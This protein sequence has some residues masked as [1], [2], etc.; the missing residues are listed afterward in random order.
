M[1]DEKQRDKIV[2][3]E[4]Q[5]I[6]QKFDELDDEVIVA[7]IENRI[8]EEWVYHFKQDNQDV[9]G[10]GKAGIDGCVSELGKKGIA[11]RE[12]NV[13]YALDPTNPQY[14][15]F[16]ATVSKHF[17]GKD[18]AEAAVER[19]I[20]TKRQWTKLKKSD[21]TVIDNRFWFEQGS[22]KALRNAKS[23]LIPEDIKA[24]IISFAK[25]HKKVKEL[26]PGDRGYREPLNDN[27]QKAWPKISLKLWDG[28]TKQ[29]TKFEALGQFGEAK[30]A[31]G[32]ENY[33]EILGSLGFEHANQIPP[34]K[35]PE[36]FKVLVT[37][38][39]QNRE[40]KAKKAG[41]L[42]RSFEEKDV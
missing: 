17:I 28:R 20:G 16:T 7:E 29:F 14:V 42:K 24:K 39:N 9:W 5:D 4:S 31:I 11:L 26:E 12:E 41:S 36:V 21:G 10:I 23:R 37:F 1:N 30:K 40:E 13:T 8:V 22:I 27:G 35:M 33:Y 38:F 2:V 18:G 3:R 15:L 19:V 6:F 25:E 34:D 32:D